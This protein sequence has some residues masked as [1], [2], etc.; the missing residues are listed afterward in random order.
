M[1]YNGN[2]FLH[3]YRSSYNKINIDQN[4]FDSVVIGL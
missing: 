2:F 4:D 3:N 1:L